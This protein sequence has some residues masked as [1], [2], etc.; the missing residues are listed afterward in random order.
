M[1]DTQSQQSQTTVSEN[2][3]TG[4]T[5]STTGPYKCATHTT[6]VIFFKKGDKFS[7]CPS[8][9]SSVGHSTTWSTVNQQ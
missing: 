7:N 6:T 5:C 2:G 9:G 4:G 8:N 3:T 1:T